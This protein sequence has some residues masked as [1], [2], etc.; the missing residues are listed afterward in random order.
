MLKNIYP[1]Q[2]IPNANTG[3][4]NARD[5]KIGDRV[6]LVLA[7]SQRP[8]VSTVEMVVDLFGSPTFTSRATAPKRMRFRFRPQDIHHL[9]SSHAAS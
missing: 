8:I 7:G 1:D 6:T 9:E 4:S 5:I 2:L 3:S